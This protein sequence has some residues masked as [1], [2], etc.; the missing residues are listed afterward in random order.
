MSRSLTKEIAYKALQNIFTQKPFIMFGTGTSCAV[1]ISFGMD[2]LKKHLLTEIP[3]KPLQP[4]QQK[5]WVSVVDSLGKG[6]DLESAMDALTD[7][8]LRQLVV[9]STAELIT[10]LD[11][12]YGVKI[13]SGENIWPASSLFKRLVDGLPEGDR[14]LHVATP[15]YDLLA[16]YAFEYADLPY[17][18]GFTGGIC[19]HI[20]WDQAKHGVMYEE[21]TVIR[22]KI[23]KTK[24]LK[25]HIRLYKVH[26]SLNTFII[27]NRIVQNNSW[28]YDR[29]DNIKRIMIIP[30]TSK[31]E[32]LH[33]Y[34]SELL[35][36]YDQAV[37]KHST[38]LF[39]GFGFNDKQLCNNAI[40][41]KLMEQKCPGLIIT[42]DSNE[43]IENLL[44]ECENLWLVCKHK[45]VGNEGTRI[46]NSRYD[47]WLN[48]DGKKLWDSSFFTQEI[49][50]G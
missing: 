48:I 38:F 7:E 44:K 11:K 47:N 30:G 15:N 19:G 8:D 14:A 36:E 16:E 25:K 27:G 39:V 21:E 28:M 23:S 26:G 37:N 50:G 6:S 10:S 4:N 22:K 12:K 33:Q 32:Y 2:A 24:K 41:K 40:V 43:R 13:A 45:D 34:R 35:L 20:D 29:P 5:Q 42:R 18:T 1:D 3:K 46:Y 49:L 17:I 31:F 9:E